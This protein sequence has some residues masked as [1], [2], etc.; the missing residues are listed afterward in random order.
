M[1]LAVVLGHV[2][3]E[4]PLV[5]ALPR[6]GVPVA[7]EVALALGATLDVLIVRKLGVPGQ[8]E[9]GMGAIGEGGVRVL[10]RTNLL[11]A[12]VSD[13][14]LAAVEAR[15]RAELDRRVCFYRGDRPM[16]SPEGRT[17]VVVDDG[18]ATGG[19]AR[20]ALRVVRNHGARRVVLAT[21]VAAA[22]TLAGL[23]ADADEVIAVAT[24]SPFRA[25]GA[26]Y[27]HFDQTTDDEVVALLLA[28]PP[29]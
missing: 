14:Q 24:P 21:P 4:R 25:I 18:I 29:T 17:V 23:A 6:G 15:E 1:R 8:P 7:Y 20:A 3:V 19:T 2:R 13:E 16:V 11:R 22:D 12:R 27:E 5:L 10:D 26:W 9:L 28:A